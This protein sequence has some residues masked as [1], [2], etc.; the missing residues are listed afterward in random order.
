MA[1]HHPTPNQNYNIDEWVIKI[2]T[3]LQEEIEDEEDDD[4]DVSKFLISITSVPKSLRS[5]APES[6]IPQLVAI[7]PYHHFRAELND[8]TRPKLSAA[9]RVQKHLHGLKLQDI[10]DEFNKAEHKIRAHYDRYLNLSVETLSWMMAIDACF[11]LEF[12]RVYAIDD[13]KALRGISPFMSRRKSTH[14]SVLRDILM[15]ENQIPLFLL[16]KVLE[17]GCASTD[18]ADGLFSTMLK[19]F[20]IEI[21][22]LKITTENFP[23]SFD[24]VKSSHLLEVLYNFLVPENAQLSETPEI[25]DED[26][27]NSLNNPAR[28]F[29][30]HVKQVLISIPVKLLLKISFRILTSLPGLL[31]LKQSLEYFSQAENSRSTNSNSS[32]NCNIKKPP[33][34][35][36]IEIP[37]ATELLSA[38]VLFSPTNQPLSEILFDIKTGTLHLPTISVDVNTEV[39]LKNLVAYETAVASG[40]LVFTRYI[41]LMNGIVD[42]ADDAKVLRKKGVILNRLKSDAKVAELWNDMSRSIK[43]TKVVF[44]D[45]VIEDV[46]AYYSKSWRV[47]GR[48]IIRIYVLGSWQL[49]VLAAAV[50][51]LL[52]VSLQ[53]FCLFFSCTHKTNLLGAGKALNNIITLLDMDPRISSRPA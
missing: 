20:I 41:E 7:G 21:S 17:V 26:D 50:L 45:K 5:A 16:K 22:P 14:N 29:L 15:L 33:F 19:N 4:G 24:V 42:T 23:Q 2:R 40:P 12:L 9:K 34:I 18:Q 1:A 48:R 28:D 51:L 38:G 3:S 31:I 36:E 11:L 6:Y 35:E 39:M 25:E 8:M 43:L 52:L 10:V 53:A 30:N 32:N 46:N 44:L 13:A 27:S 47:R 37:S 49:F